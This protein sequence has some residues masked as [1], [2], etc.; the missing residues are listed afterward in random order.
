[1]ALRNIWATGG[2]AWPVP[3]TPQVPAFQQPAPQSFYNP[4]ARPGG[5]VPNQASLEVLGQERKVDTNFFERMEYN[6][7]PALGWAVQQPARIGERPLAA[8]DFVAGGAISKGI[9]AVGDAGGSGGEP[10]PIGGFFGFLGDAITN[11]SNIPAALMNADEA[12]TL[13]AV[14][15]MRDD[16]ELPFWLGRHTVDGGLLGFF[17]LGGRQMTVGEFKE[18]LRK[19]QFFADGQGGELDYEAVLHKAKTDPLGFAN[20]RINDSLAVDFG[21]RML[22]DPLNLAFFI[23][24]GAVARAAGLVGKAGA[25]PA[26]WATRVATVGGEKIGIGYVAEMSARGLRASKLPDATGAAVALL[27]GEI[28][29][30]SLAG[31]AKALDMSMRGARVGLQK[32][33]LPG[34]RTRSAA[35]L[36][37]LGRTGLQARA[38]QG[39][40]LLRAYQ[41]GA[42]RISIG[43]VAAEYGSKAAGG[44]LEDQI[45]EN[46]ISDALTDTIHN[47][48]KKI[49][50]NHLLSDN[51]LFVL[52]AAV[53]LPTIPAVGEY[54][55]FARAGAHRLVGNNDAVVFAKALIPDTE[56]IKN[57][58]QNAQVENMYKMFGRG[59]AAKGKN[60]FQFMIDFLD[61]S[62]AWKEIAK[63]N[64]RF[65][66][67]DELTAHGAALA[68]LLEEKVANMRRLGRVNA[69]GRLAEFNE[70]VRHGDADRPFEFNITNDGAIE[71]WITLYDAYSRFGGKLREFGDLVIEESTIMT[72]EM[73]DDFLRI[74]ESE[75]D[76][77]ASRALITEL[78]S[79]YPALI[80][81]TKRYGDFWARLA[82]QGDN[83]AKG[84]KPGAPD[85]AVTVEQV[86]S[87]LQALIDED[88]LPSQEELFREAIQLE[89]GAPPLPDLSKS[90]LRRVHTMK[91]LDD[92]R[93]ETG[94]KTRALRKEEQ[95]LARLRNIEF[96]RNGT[97][98]AKSLKKTM[99]YAGTE[100]KKIDSNLPGAPDQFRYSILHLDADE[101]SQTI[102]I[103]DDG[104][105]GLTQ[106]ETQ[107]LDDVS[108]SEA[109]VKAVQLGG[110]VTTV[111]RRAA[112]E[113]LAAHGFVEVG[114]TPGTHI[115]AYVGGDP[116]TI[117]SRISYPVPARVEGTWVNTE[118][119]GSAFVVLPIEPQNITV[120]RLIDYIEVDRS[121]TPKLASDPGYLARLEKEILKSKRMDPIELSYDFVRKTAMI[122][123]GN[124]RLAIARKHPKLFKE[125]PVV[126]RIDLDLPTDAKRVMNVIP[127]WADRA[128]TVAE[129]VGDIKHPF[130][131]YRQSNR[132][133]KSTEAGVSFAKKRA[134]QASLRVPSTS[135]IGPSPFNAEG[136]FHGSRADFDQFMNE[137]MEESALVGPGVYTTDAADIAVGYATES[138]QL[139]RVEIADNLNLL[140]LEK[141]YSED[142]IVRLRAEADEYLSSHNVSDEDFPTWEYI[143]DWVGEVSGTTPF[144]MINSVFDMSGAQMHVPLTRAIQEAAKAL[145]YDGFQHTGGGRT[146]NAP[147]TVRVIFDADNVKI[148]EK[149]RVQ[150]LVPTTKARFKLITERMNVLR[151]QQKA[152]AQ[153]IREI[154]ARAE[155]LRTIKLDDE[156]LKH[157]P[158]DQQLALRELVSQVR[159]EYPQY[160]VTYKPGFHFDPADGLLPGLNL[161][162]NLAR[163]LLYDYGPLS[164][165]ANLYHGLF[166]PISSKAQS[167]AARQAVFNLALPLG[168]TTK[169]MERILNKL[170]ENVRGLTETSMRVPWFRDITSLPVSRIN[171]IARNAVDETAWAKIESVYGKEGFHRLLD[172]AANEFVR[173]FDAKARR[174]QKNGM[175]Q[176][177]MR[178]GYRRWAYAPVVGSGSRLISKQFYHIFRFMLDLRWHFLNLVEADILSTFRSGI[179][180]RTGQTRGNVS[181]ESL[182]AHT[183]AE[184]LPAGVARAMADGPATAMELFDAGLY[185]HNRNLLPVLERNFDAARLESVNA[186]LDQLPV[187]HPVIRALIERFGYSPDM[188]YSPGT[189]WISPSELAQYLEM[190]TPEQVIATKR[191][192]YGDE[193]VDLLRESISDGITP[194]LEEPITLEW[195]GQSPVLTDGNTRVALALEM[196]LDKVP[197]VVKAGAKGGRKTWSE[198][199]DDMMY[200]FDTKGVHQSF[201]DEFVQIAKD[202]GWSTS[203]VTEFTKVIERISEK[204]QQAYDDLVALYQGN[205]NR[206]RLERLMNSYWLYWPISYQI[207]A[208]KWLFN[209][210][211]N[212][213]G[214]RQTNL[215]GAYLVDR[216]ADRFFEELDSDPEFRRQFEDQE[217]LWFVAAMFFPATPVDIGVSLN[218][219]VRYAGSLLAPEIIPP[220]AGIDGFEDI[221]PRMLELGPV[222]S[223]RLFQTLFNELGE[224]S[225]SG[226]ELPDLPSG[227]QSGLDAVL[228]Q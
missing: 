191:D 217:D 197:V 121:V 72:R 36:T 43:S 175:L 225:P 164:R 143:R 20:A 82:V 182:M 95:T 223:T 188:P 209:V 117:T 192:F 168:V 195:G 129:L 122:T 41:R 149:V 71:K 104:T 52:T 38:L 181:K 176:A 92:M 65:A 1:M 69:K 199:L 77:F 220:Y 198:M 124:H 113:E 9:K 102:N 112:A 74:L 141:P 114:Q 174:S 78:F 73:A 6:A 32:T 210:L 50:N 136:I 24:G 110:R 44:W 80:N 206:N 56:G 93:Q 224:D 212:R 59:D 19:R 35:E 101:P 170:N 118:D 51:E 204:N 178:E 185:L 145:G 70:W 131:P 208:T 213:M 7:L 214:G 201:M 142:M 160:D 54:V 68:P 31:L 146:G 103:Y 58:T 30:G 109:I 66:S 105:F 17:G 156:V 172:E 64:K 57:L 152:N 171:Q 161:E 166:D 49:N 130:G 90:P 200:D 25:L 21:M 135:A 39:H 79:R 179:N 144:D 137:F 100:F 125:I 91:Q 139:Y 12:M 133:F 37:A 5:R 202:E 140:D 2:S 167:K 221:A 75:P 85:I 184:G 216:Q 173:T 148:G 207:K 162:R 63:A 107:F 83:A 88:K 84:G 157:V 205:L 203:E 10:G 47:A 86:R 194:G 116:T 61:Q 169:Q 60:V 127:R 106:L 23:P 13:D 76:G 99:G 227:S 158:E 3:A 154:D 29:D 16:E 190:A 97:P 163:H 222:Y 187:D 48:F 126:I 67:Q 45:G 196:G 18:D 94:G 4:N 15:G 211:A 14:S 81:D 53:T 111:S 186:V 115:M 219:G 165:I 8:L 55:G 180:R 138:G 155:E 159:D 11:I 147:H 128:I 98:K 26:K 87:E 150:D 177:A 226:P 123:D 193:Y 22:T 27:R 40:D 42:L 62:R 215:A 151:E 96:T 183:T 108:A 189:H 134:A 34:L 46:V 120:E 89:K 132:T 33:L 218:R 153:I 28:R 119:G 228:G